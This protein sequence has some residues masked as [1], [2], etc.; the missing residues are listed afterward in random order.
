MKYIIDIPN[1]EINRWICGTP[2]GKRLLVPISIEEGK[3]H[4]IKTDISVQNYSE[5]Y[6]EDIENEVWELANYMGRMSLTERDLCFGFPLPQEVTMNLSYQE[7]K[8]R[9]EAWMKSENEINVGDEVFHKNY[10]SDKGVVTRLYQSGY[11][12]A[13]ILFPDG[14][15]D[16]EILVNN[17]VKTGRHFDEVEVLLKKIG[18]EE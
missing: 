18:S 4:N 13:D 8:D 9:F 11:M 10:P 15:I 14:E 1:D 12:C 17:L 5:L 2:Y 7:A 3:E 6:Q 16:K